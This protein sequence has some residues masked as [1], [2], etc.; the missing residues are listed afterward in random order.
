MKWNKNLMDLVLYCLYIP[1][2]VNVA[3]WKMPQ[4]NIMKDVGSSI[5]GSR[6]QTK[7]QDILA[8]AALILTI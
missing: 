1:F 2:G 7:S 8:T 5:W 3:S 4:S 6:P